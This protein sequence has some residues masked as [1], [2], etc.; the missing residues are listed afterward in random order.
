MQNHQIKIEFGQ[1][2]LSSL[3]TEE[4]FRREA[5]NLLP[6]ALVQLGEAIGE[7]TWNTLQQGKKGSKFKVNTSS[8]EKQK[9]VKE[10]GKN[11]KTKAS[12]KDRKEL[13]DYIVQELR[14]HQEEN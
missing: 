6:E 3:E 14:K 1:V 13:E 9:F 4:D 10:T 12:A 11:Y 5:K 8:A 2:D 7:E